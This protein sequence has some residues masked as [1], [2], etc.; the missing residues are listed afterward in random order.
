MCGG[1][2]FLIDKKMA[3]SANSKGGLLLRIDPTQTVSLVSESH[4]RPW[5]FPADDAGLIIAFSAL[6]HLSSRDAFCA[7]LERCRAATIPG[8]VNVIGIVADRVEVS[9]SGA[10]RAAV[11]ELPLS[12]GQ[13]LS[14]LRLC[15][16]G[17]EIHVDETI[18][19]AVTERR[20]SELHE[21]RSAPIKG[22]AL[23]GLPQMIG[24]RLP[25]YGR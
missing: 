14:V 24:T 22:T 4:V 11:I 18:P 2:A 25:E 7:I 3:V 17:W 6:E 10:R 5:A 13:A 19:A 12:G 1:L 23:T 20:N 9:S 15:F 16:A 8:G 21:L